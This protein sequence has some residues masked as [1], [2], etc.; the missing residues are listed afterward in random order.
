MVTFEHFEKAVNLAHELNW[1]HV[2][3][4]LIL[5]FLALLR[6]SNIAPETSDD[7]DLSRNTLL[8][9]LKVIDNSL[10]IKIKWAKNLQVG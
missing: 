2:K 9:D 7:L 6:I 5:G 3:L 4:S 10:L 8:S 1:P